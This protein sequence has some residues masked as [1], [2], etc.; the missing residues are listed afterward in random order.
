MRCSNTIVPGFEETSKIKNPGLAAKLEFALRKGEVEAFHGSPDK[1]IKEFKL[2]KKAKNRT[3]NPAGIYS[4]ANIDEAR[5][6]GDN[7]YRLGV[8][9]GKVFDLQSKNRHKYPITKSMVDKYKE[10]LPRNGYTL[11][12]ANKSGIISDFKKTGKMKPISSEDKRA[13][14]LAGGYDT[15]LDSHFGKR[16]YVSLH[17][18]AVRIREYL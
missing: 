9:K 15:L 12:W 11:D 13:V 6:Y 14:F 10:V 2:G 17:P 8:E 16:H 5:S 1:N 3:G 18:E 4:A 7:V